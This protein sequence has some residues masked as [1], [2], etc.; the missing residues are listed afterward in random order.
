M[1]GEEIKAESLRDWWI[2]EFRGRDN[3]KWPFCDPHYH[4]VMPGA[5][6]T[7][8]LREFL[9]ARKLEAIEELL[10]MLSTEGQA[11]RA[12]LNLIMGKLEEEDYPDT[13]GGRMC[14]EL[15]AVVI[16]G[17]R[18]AFETR[19]DEGWIFATMARRVVPVWLADTKE[20]PAAIHLRTMPPT[21]RDMILACVPT[22]ALAPFR[23]RLQ[24]DYGLRCYGN[25]ERWNLAQI[26]RSGLFNLP[27]DKAPLPHSVTKA[28]LVESG[29][30]AGMDWKA[31]WKRDR[32]INEAATAGLLMGIRETH[33]PEERV[34]RDRF[35]Q[36]SFGKFQRYTDAMWSLAGRDIL[37]ARVLR[38]CMPGM[39]KAVYSY[40]AGGGL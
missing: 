12:Q 14:A 39:E 2:R 25:S 38:F 17:L 13:D 27:D 26:T 36:D 37:E 15:D 10:W 29:L 6:F 9:I 34:F 8:A 3:P 23:M 16:L 40:D 21:C 19:R 5:D 11:W 7:V 24:R 31:S 28:A 30:A 4:T 35:T 18:V 33:A 32:L 1:K 20:Q 22:G